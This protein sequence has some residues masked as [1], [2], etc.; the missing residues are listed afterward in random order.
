MLVSQEL[1]ARFVTG[2][3]RQF[4]TQRELMRHSV[5]VWENKL[6]DLPVTRQLGYGQELVGIQPDCYD[7]FLGYM[8]GMLPLL[9]AQCDGGFSI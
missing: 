6:R 3:P 4:P 9:D 7:A 5:Q 1:I 8:K 2:D